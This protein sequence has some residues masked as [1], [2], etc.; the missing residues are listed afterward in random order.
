MG[1]WFF[2]LLALLP[3]I[4]GGVLFINSKRINWQEWIINSVVV[5]LL[6]GLM[7]WIA[8][9]GMTSDVETWS[10]QIVQSVER[11]AWR[12]YYE[13][14]VYRTVYETHTDSKGNSY[15]TSYEVFDHWES[16]RRWHNIH[17]QAYSNIDTSYEITRDHHYYSAG[18][19]Q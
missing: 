6:A 16:H 19:V 17:W 15:T 1:V 13:E 12:E 14:A 4:V 18:E 9:A 7:H 2:Y 11:S 8:I 5:F 10:G 3:L